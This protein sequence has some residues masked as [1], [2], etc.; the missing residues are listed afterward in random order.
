MKEAKATASGFATGTD[1]SRYEGVG[2]RRYASH[3]KVKNLNLGRLAGG[4]VPR[5]AVRR[6]GSAF[7]TPGA[8]RQQ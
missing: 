1:G 3:G 5:R 8:Q 2:K 7:G 4:L 6:Y